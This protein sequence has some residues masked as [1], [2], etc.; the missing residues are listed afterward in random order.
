MSKTDTIDTER[1]EHSPL[2]ASGSGRW[3]NCPG[4]IQLQKK[5]GIF[6]TESGFAAK[7]GTAAHEV[8]A[9]CLADG[10]KLEPLDFI[11]RTV[12]VEGTSFEVD[13]KMVEALNVC[14]NHVYENMKM[15]HAKGR[16]VSYIEVSMQHSKHELMFGTTDCAIVC[17]MDNG[18]VLIWVNDL[19]YGQGIVVEPTT[20][21][22]K[23]YATLVADRLLKEGI[24]QSYDDIELVYLTIM[25]PRIPHTNGLVRTT[26]M[27]GGELYDWYRH[28]LVPAMK[29]TENPDAI[30]QMGDWCTF[31]PVKT[32]CPA[33]A[34]AV[35]DFS[36]AK[37]PEDMDGDELGRAIMKLTAII[38]LKERYE[39]VALKKALRGEKIYGK[40]LVKQ[41]ANRRLREGI[42]ELM[43]IETYGDAAF[44]K[45]LIGIPDIEK[46]PDGKTFVAQYAFQP[47][48]A[49]LTLAPL[50][51]NRKEAKPLMAA[52]EEF[53]DSFDGLG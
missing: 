15:A 16:I 44:S 27:T 39:A 11:G 1:I 50:S 3:M 20:S 42:G 25:Q 46:L 41:K 22:I 45:K 43:L 48:D 24:I 14:Y 18:K 49:G 40:K 33:M 35:V 28:V 53:E 19:K 34:T 17:I 51:D 52:Y 6:Q 2:G 32:H 5:L 47:T 12:V 10:M 36:S 37:R 4:S 21:Q 23:Y 30:L 29:E 38:N 9:Q 8:L 31:C 26:A 13:Q 7:E